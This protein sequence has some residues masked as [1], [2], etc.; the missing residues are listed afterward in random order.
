L[1]V[2]LNCENAGTSVGSSF[3]LSAHQKPVPSF[4]ICRFLSVE[5]RTA[6]AT[7]LNSCFASLN[8]FS[9]STGLS[10]VDCA[11]IRKLECGCEQGSWSSRWVSSEDMIRRALAD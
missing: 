11:G 1:A 2:L 3:Q 6:R 10:H 4:P 9:S 7:F 8:F 5:Q